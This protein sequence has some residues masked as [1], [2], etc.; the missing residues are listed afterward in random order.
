M[1]LSKAFITEA[2]IKVIALY[3]P[4][5]SPHLPDMEF[6][7]INKEV[8]E[9]DGRTN[10]SFRFLRPGC[11]DTMCTSTNTR[12]CK[13]VLKI[14][15]TPDLPQDILRGLDSCELISVF[16]CL[17]GYILVPTMSHHFSADT[18]H[19]HHTRQCKFH[20]VVLDELT[21]TSRFCSGD[22]TLHNSNQLF[23]FA[24]TYIVRKY[25]SG[26]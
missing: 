3:M 23:I 21:S 17:T 19:A 24:C 8:L 10:A 7:R 6:S 9:M 2:N 13:G 4:G 16:A 5:L 22:I 14:P 26:L 1:M 25:N 11:T 20:Q 12:V 18:A 15:R